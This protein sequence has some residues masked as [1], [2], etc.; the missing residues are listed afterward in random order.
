MGLVE[1]LHMCLSV[2]VDFKFRLRILGSF[3]HSV[4]SYYLFEEVIGNY[5]SEDWTKRILPFY[6]L[7]LQEYGEL[8][9]G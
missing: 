7:E 1:F 9:R 4:L 8:Q 2:I 5:E 6:V 3:D